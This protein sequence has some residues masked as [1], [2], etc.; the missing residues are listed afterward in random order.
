MKLDYM[1]VNSFN[2]NSLPVILVVEGL[3]SEARPS[4]C[5]PPARISKHLEWQRLCAT[6]TAAQQHCNVPVLITIT[7]YQ[8]TITPESLDNL[9]LDRSEET[10]VH[11]DVR[12][13]LVVSDLRPINDIL[14]TC[15]RRICS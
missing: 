7:H 6:S 4:G 12:S 5:S 15:N 9:L 14:Y 10:S 11:D 1:L 2:E 8:V 13:R 3:S